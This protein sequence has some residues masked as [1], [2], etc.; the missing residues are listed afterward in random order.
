MCLH[1]DINV[2][3]VAS[4]SFLETIVMNPAT[5]NACGR[6]LS[7]TASFCPDC[8][9]SVGAPGAPTL[10]GD[11]PS[12]AAMGEPASPGAPAGAGSKNAVLGWF[13]VGFLV[14]NGVPALIA[15]IQPTLA[16]FAIG[17]AVSLALTRIIKKQFSTGLMIGTAVVCILLSLV[18]CISAAAQAA[19]PGSGSG[20]LGELG[21]LLVPGVLALVA[22]VRGR[23]KT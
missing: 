12:A 17:L 8:G 22:G 9:V 4:R 7:A 20:S 3:I 10:A 1:P 13:V 6:S 2:R 16:L 15:P 11:Q 5:C 19:N 21:G 14:S 23:S 18:G